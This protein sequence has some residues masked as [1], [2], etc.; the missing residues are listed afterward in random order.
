MKDKI[1]SNAE[2]FRR[3]A[4]E[5]MSVELAYDLEGVRWLDGFI[6]RQRAG[7]SQDTKNKLPNTAG[8]YLG[9]C[10]RKTYGGAWTQDAEGGWGVR[11]NER[12]TVFPFNKV[13]KQLANTE[14][15]SVLGLFT[16]IPPL[17]KNPPSA[18]IKHLQKRPWWRFW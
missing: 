15:D 9:E 10:I 6:N 11:I 13:Q 14:G 18:K 2:F 16:A 8:S 5:Q 7:A 12:I 1:Q 3:I 17:L 4:K